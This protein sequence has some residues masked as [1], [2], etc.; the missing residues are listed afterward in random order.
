MWSR[1]SKRGRRIFHNVEYD[2]FEEQKLKELE[3]ELEKNK[4][5]KLW[6][7]WTRVESLKMLYNGNFEI[8]KAL[9]VTYFS[10][11]ISWGLDL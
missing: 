11:I 9:E 2:A 5:I 8:K 4:E 10:G 7:H 3:E 6:E 1:S